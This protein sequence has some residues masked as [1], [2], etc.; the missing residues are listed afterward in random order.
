MRILYVTIVC[1]FVLFLSIGAIKRYAYHQLI[2]L[3]ENKEYAR[4][5]RLIDSKRMKLLFPKLVLLDM[6]LN[7][8][9]LRQDKAQS[10]Q[11]I[12]EICHLPL[13][14]SQKETYYLKA[15]NL[16]VGIEDKKNSKK[17]LDL[18]Q[19][20]SNEKMK[21]ETRRVYNIYID[22]NDHDLKDL[23]KE[24][25]DMEED[26]KGIHEFL[27]SKIYANKKDPVNARKYEQLSKEHL[28]LI[29]SR[30]S[31]KKLAH[32]TPNKHK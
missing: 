1:A 18:I 23:I 32:P 20:G 7:A 19:K 29:D 25:D 16:Y 14:S 5:D 28:A 10:I 22:K 15:F 6:K 4:F 12:E 24:L 21:V 9:L 13:T 31:E 30:T 17:Y 27:I 3:L 11:W 2:T 8:S 26:Q